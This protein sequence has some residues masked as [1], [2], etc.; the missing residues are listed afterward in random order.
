MSV[1][2]PEPADPTAIVFEADTGV[3]DLPDDRFH[4]LVDTWRHPPPY[5]LQ[6]ID[7]LLQSGAVGGHGPHPALVPGLRA[8][9]VDVC[10][11]RTWRVGK[12]GVRVQ[13]GWLLGEVAALLD[14]EP[15]GRQQFRTVPAEGLPGAL[16]AVVDIGPRDWPGDEPVTGLTNRRAIDAILSAHLPLHEVGLQRIA[17][18]L[19]PELHDF[20]EQFADPRTAAWHAE[21]VFLRPDGTRRGRGVIAIDTPRGYLVAT[22]LAGKRICLTP[23][24][25][26]N[27][28]RRLLRM[29]PSV[30]EM[31]VSRPPSLNGDQSPGRNPQGG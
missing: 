4:A 17:E 23:A 1:E 2:G 8:V 24:S 20:A 30:V 3:V 25:P 12:P 15:G 11:V 14:G 7:D 18:Q 5:D 10:R 27:V 28:W 21:L 26:T 31:A 6:S 22:P 13:Q 19:P 9:A 29:L 16:A